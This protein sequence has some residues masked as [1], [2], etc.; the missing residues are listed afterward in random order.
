MASKTKADPTGQRDNRLRARKQVDAR[1]AA[2]QVKVLALFNAIPRTRTYEAT[3]R[4]A[5][6]AVYDYDISPQ[7]VEA[8]D[9]AVAAVVATA[10]GTTSKRMDEAWWY[11]P[12]VELPFRQGM[13]QELIE[14]NQLL[15]GAV[16]AGV[17][18]KGMAPR[19]MA[20][21]LVLSSPAYFE[22]LNYE[23]VRNYTI[24]SNLSA[25]TSYQVMERIEAGLQAGSTPQTIIDDI[26][27]RFGVAR[28]NAKRIVDTEVN[29]AYNNA[30]MSGAE[31]AH[32]ET[33]LRSAVRHISARTATTR[34]SHALR[35]NKVY[36]VASQRQWWDRGANQIN[37]K[38]TIRTVLIDDAG[39]VIS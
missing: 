7:Q 30:K 33:G 38:C 8:L 35:H 19:P 10:L 31:L 18:V 17:T 29:W 36:T 20:V 16:V 24:F 3:I 6:T 39:K 25:K 4:N 37:C 13:T 26:S 11:K 23:Y 32:D 1:L 2:A 34:P 21:E 14:F 22:L 5:E 28:S 15:A 27:K 12:N 9:A